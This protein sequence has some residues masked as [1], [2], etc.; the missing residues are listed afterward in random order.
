MALIFLILGI[1][2]LM[3]ACAGCSVAEETGIMAIFGI[4]ITFFCLILC[5][6]EFRVDSKYQVLLSKQ[7]L[8]NKNIAYYN[9][10]TGAFELKDLSKGE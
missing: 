1:I 3:L 7:E 2:G 10:T 8:I 9:T 5:G 4:L 6:M